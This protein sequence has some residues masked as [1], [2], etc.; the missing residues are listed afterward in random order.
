MRSAIEDILPCVRVGSVLPGHG[1]AV[2]IEVVVPVKGEDH[3]V[4]FSRDANGRKR[5]TWATTEP[6]QFVRSGYYR[7]VASVIHAFGT[8][9]GRDL[10]FYQDVLQ[11]L[12][13]YVSAVA[14]AALDA[15]DANRAV[16]A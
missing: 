2:V 6:A 10:A 16:A 11:A 1:Q 5:G 15:Y 8:E 9:T 14:D 3:V 4:V 13:G 12:H 7:M